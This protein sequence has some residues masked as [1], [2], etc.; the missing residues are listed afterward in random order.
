M[1][2][3]A[4]FI[5]KIE[6]F[7]NNAKQIGIILDGKPHR[8]ATVDKPKKLNGMYA[9]SYNDIQ[10]YCAIW[11]WGTGEHQT[12][13]PDNESITY[14]KETLLKLEQ[15]KTR[16][17]IEEQQ[18]YERTSLKSTKIY[19]QLSLNGKS[20]YVNRK[21]IV[22]YN[23]KF[24][25]LNDIVVPVYDCFGKIWGLQYI[26]NNGDKKFSFGLKKKGNFGIIGCDIAELCYQQTIYLAEGYATANSIWQATGQPV[27]VA[28]DCN[29]I[30]PVIN[31]IKF[32]FPSIN[33]VICAD[34]DCFGPE[35]VGVEKAEK[36]SKKYNTTYIFP[37]FEQPN[38]EKY[39][40][41]NDYHV[42]YGVERLKNYINS[43]LILKK[44][45]S[46]KPTEDFVLAD[47]ED[48]IYASRF[49]HM[50]NPL[51][52]FVDKK[53]PKIL[54]NPP[55]NI[56][57]FLDYVIRRK[58]TVRVQPLMYVIN[59]IT[60]LGLLL[61]HKVRSET[62]LRT[63]ILSF[64]VA[65]SACGKDASMKAIQDIAYHIGYNLHLTAEASSSG[66][67]FEEL[68]KQDGKIMMQIDE[69]ATFIESI[70][71]KGSAGYLKQVSSTIMEAYTSAGNIM[72]ESSAKTRD[73][74]VVNQP[75]LCF[76]GATT[77]KK[78][79]DS[80]HSAETLSG[81]L[82]RFVMVKGEPH[83]IEKDENLN[84][85]LDEIPQEIVDYCNA[86][87]VMPDNV[88]I[89]ANMEIK[90]DGEKV[91]IPYTMQF[92]TLAEAM[93]K[94]FKDYINKKLEICDQ[95]NLDAEDALLRRSVVKVIQIAMI[96][97][98]DD[99]ES[100]D[101]C[102]NEEA[103]A[104]AIA[105]VSYSDKLMLDIINTCLYN[106]PHQQHCNNIRREIRE[107]YEK[108]SE[109]VSV[110]T[111]Y[112]KFITEYGSKETDECL[113]DLVKEGSILLEFAGEK[114]NFYYP[115]NNKSK[116]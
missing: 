29:N 4:G 101:L 55:K 14:D 66:G 62:N 100:Q 106:T 31:N 69:V 1:I 17:K 112:S 2:G 74:I 52:K 72:Q 49:E 86:I 15:H 32:N 116:L 8:Y 103:L 6:G 88:E 35:N 84:Q 16:L 20:E 41:F 19:K 38:T 3:E 42:K 39:T 104:Y 28:F 56:K 51:Y 96:C 105:L 18:K 68:N 10:K 40:D 11:N 27:V 5:Q 97:S 79:Y 59:I 87:L 70:F 44:Q 21:Q 71:A 53:T 9:G 12:I 83:L 89:G 22:P 45:D 95:L 92:S 110:S 24:N 77:P 108:S 115:N 78:F 60:F 82:S 48:V 37:I 99:P 7:L 46:E 75:H 43:S 33:I 67:I 64:V 34:N 26:K 63:N 109:K 73:K 65:K 23:V 90:K 91:I 111:I 102:I 113:K 50:D 58:S 13:Y 94:K 54:L 76:F 36:A 98:I 57:M 30:E 93:F 114:G 107:L 61:G 81:F 80:I 25:T 85:F 47:L